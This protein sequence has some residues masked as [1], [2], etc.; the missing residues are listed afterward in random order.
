M[1]QIKNLH[2]EFIK[3]GA[4]NLNALRVFILAKNFVRIFNRDDIKHQNQD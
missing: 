4:I 2:Q 3:M 1:S